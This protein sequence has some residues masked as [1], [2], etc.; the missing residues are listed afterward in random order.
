[1]RDTNRIQCQHKTSATNLHSEAANQDPLGVATGARLR[2]TDHIPSEIFPKGKDLVP[3][4]KSSFIASNTKLGN[5]VDKNIY[6]NTV[7]ALIPPLEN[8]IVRLEQKSDAENN[9]FTSV[10]AVTSNPMDPPAIAW[11]QRC[12]K[13]NPPPTVSTPVKH[14]VPTDLPGATIYS[15]GTRRIHHKSNRIA[16]NQFRF[17]HTTQK[18]SHTTKQSDKS[19]PQSKI[20]S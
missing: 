1:M 9:K 11:T 10:K 2:S 4:D 15:I 5:S 6:I 3:P 12:T 14:G 17:T 8:D 18:H 7:I 19:P 16:S 13:L 20:F